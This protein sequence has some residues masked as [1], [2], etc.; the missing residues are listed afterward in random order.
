MTLHFVTASRLPA[1][2]F[3][4]TSLLGQ[5]LA[6][7]PAESYRLS[8]H[9]DNTGPRLRGLPEV[10]NRAISRAD[11]DDV[12][13]FVHD[14]VQLH[15]PV[16]LL[17]M[18]LQAALRTAEVIGTAGASGRAAHEKLPL[19]WALDFDDRLQC[20]GW[21]SGPAYAG[22]RLSGCVSHSGAAARDNPAIYG[23]APRHCDLLDGLLLAVTARSL[24]EKGVQ[25]DPRFHFHFYD[26]DFCMAAS[27]ARLRLST[28]PLHVTHGSGG[29]FGLP[30]WKRSA[31]LYRDKWQ[32]PSEP[33]SSSPPR[34]RL[35]DPPLSE[36]A[37]L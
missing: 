20:R 36:P 23:S 5:S 24:W 33:A 7:S 34:W 21:R 15:T 9:L 3:W 26:L 32:L 14:D 8:A 30:E 6:Q 35:P 1:E 28:W 37:P 12:L 11:P 10:Y 19:S 29:A 27:S 25:F 13:V 18:Q 4:S 2:L 17:E 31:E 22:V 16:P